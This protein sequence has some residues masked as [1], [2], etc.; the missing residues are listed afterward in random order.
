LNP[1]PQ[2]GGRDSLGDGAASAVRDAAAGRWA[3]VTDGTIRD[4]LVFAVSPVTI[5]RDLVASTSE[6]AAMVA[7]GRRLRTTT[8][9]LQR[10][11]SA[12]RRAGSP[13]SKRHVAQATHAVDRSR[14][15]RAD[16]IEG[17]HRVAF[18]ERATRRLRSPRRVRAARI[19]VVEN[20]L[21]SPYRCAVRDLEAEFT[22]L[23]ER[24]RELIDVLLAARDSTEDFAMKLEALARTGD[25]RARASM[26]IEALRLRDMYDRALRE[27]QRQAAAGGR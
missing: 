5:A 14:A 18:R 13:S 3:S 27:L 20:I 6:C 9:R 22:S 21:S 17:S 12:I 8:A 25:G 2:S 26:L 1:S 16:G 11:P 15:K 4:V 7:H 10:A 19:I 24:H 23:G